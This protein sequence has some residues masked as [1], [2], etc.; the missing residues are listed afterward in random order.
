MPGSFKED[1]RRAETR[2]LEHFVWPVRFTPSTVSTLVSTHDASQNALDRGHLFTRRQ[3]RECANPS[4]VIIYKPEHPNLGILHYPGVK[5]CEETHFLCLCLKLK[6][7]FLCDLDT[8]THTAQTIRSAWLHA[9]QGGDVLRGKSAEFLI[10]IRTANRQRAG[11]LELIE[12]VIP[13]DVTRQL[14]K[15]NRIHSRGRNGEKRNTRISLAQLHQQ[16]I[17]ACCGI[18]PQEDRTTL[19]GGCSKDS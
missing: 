3:L 7:H 12:G 15:T 4:K 6:N 18:T 14:C 9:A 5:D 11:T 13:P 10:L 2:W 1:H 8:F 16:G 17:W 19:A